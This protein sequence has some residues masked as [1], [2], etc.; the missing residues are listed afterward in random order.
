MGEPIRS[1]YGRMECVNLILI[2][3]FK[4]FQ[5][6]L[7]LLERFNK[8]SPVFPYDRVETRRQGKNERDN[9]SIYIFANSAG[10]EK[11]KSQY[12]AY[13]HINRNQNNFIQLFELVKAGELRIM[14]IRVLV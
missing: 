2:A 7:K 9:S 6:A 4:F 1:S 8:A 3:A 5:Y 11:V 13:C 14:K 12:R 10:H